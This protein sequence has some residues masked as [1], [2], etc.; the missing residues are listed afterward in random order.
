[1]ASSSPA[2]LSQV[3]PNNATTYERAMAAQVERLLALDVPIADLWNPQKCPVDLLPYLAWALSVDIWKTDWPEF[4]KRAVIA[5][6]VKLHRLKGTETALRRYV[7]QVDAKVLQVVTPPQDFFAA[8]DPSK[9]EMD[10]Y[11]RKLP[12]LRLYTGQDNGRD[13]FGLFADMG[14]ADHGFATL[15]MGPALYGRRAT[16]RRN[17]VDEPL[18]VVTIETVVTERGVRDVERTSIPGDAGFAFF[19][20]FSFADHAFADTVR[21]EAKVVTVELDRTYD[22]EESTLRLDMV[23]PGLD[24][25][26]P[27]YERASDIGEPDFGFYADASFADH[28][29]AVPDRSG[30]LLFDR[31]YLFDPTIPSPLAGPGGF[32]DHTRIGMDGFTA[33]V[34]IDASR[35]A[36][37]G[38]A[39]ANTLFADVS[40]AVDEDEGRYGEILQA[41]NVSK[42]LTDTVLVTFE[43]T[44]SVTLDDGIDLNSDADMEA[45]ISRHI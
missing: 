40:F 32:A 44:R 20:D 30:E 19:A 34:M 36:H 7:D 22:H 10:A 39:F 41:V 21:K 27:R 2:L 8:A 5:E 6:A 16:V 29:F 33:E 26:N 37:K 42:S 23:A 25:V 35:T 17:G 3:L 15:D 24:P 31:L 11:V 1:M 28:A 18:K 12:Q 45:R 14:F 43:T 38:E 9:E 13:E 4:K